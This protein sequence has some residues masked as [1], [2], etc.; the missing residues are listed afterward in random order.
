MKRGE[1]LEGVDFDEEVVA[2]VVG[3]SPGHETLDNLGLHCAGLD[4]RDADLRLPLAFKTSL[5]T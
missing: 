1:F 5:R 3:K 4:H 2:L